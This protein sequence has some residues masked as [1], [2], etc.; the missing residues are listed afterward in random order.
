M[1]DARFAKPLDEELICDLARTCGRMVTVEE[2]VAAG[3]FGSAVLEAL[4][5]RGLYGVRTRLVAVDDV[6]VEHGAQAILREKY[7]VD[8]QAVTR[9][10][11][12]L[13]AS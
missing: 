1:V 8:A 11:R 2:N 3:G 7:G 9:A 6:F 4:S 13:M 10:A 12:E 5:R